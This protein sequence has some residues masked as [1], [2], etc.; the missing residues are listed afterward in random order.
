MGYRNTRLDSEPHHTS[1]KYGIFLHY[2]YNRLPLSSFLSPTHTSNNRLLNPPLITLRRSSRT[3]SLYLCASFL[4][5]SPRETQQRLTQSINSFLVLW[6]HLNIHS[7]S[8]LWLSLPLSFLPFRF[9]PLFKLKLLPLHLLLPATV[10]NFLSPFLLRSDLLL[11][12][13][14]SR[15]T[16]SGFYVF[17]FY[18]ITYKVSISCSEKSPA[19]LFSTCIV[20]ISHE[21]LSFFFNV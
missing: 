4:F 14:R 7:D 12:H 19:I 17:T 20:F 3:I 9:L 15:K 21:L 11:Y 6:L 2:R 5:I 13:S 10:T 16:R 18:I 1:F 8:E